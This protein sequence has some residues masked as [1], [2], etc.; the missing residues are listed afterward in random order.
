M[1]IN[2]DDYI[3]ESE[4]KE[5]AISVFSD[6]I[7]SAFGGSEYTDSGKERD[8]I[9]KNAVVKWIAEYVETI[10]TDEDKALIR[11]ETYKAIKGASYEFKIFQ[12][13]DIWDRDEYSV[14]KIIQTAVK[15][16]EEFIK[17]RVTESVVN[18]FTLPTHNVSN[19]M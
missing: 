4:K 7:K 9:V 3:S 1:N 15:E 5:I 6:S 19:D 12:K 14:Y 13:P 2:I 17:K 11:E 8:R 18:M 10:L 16:N